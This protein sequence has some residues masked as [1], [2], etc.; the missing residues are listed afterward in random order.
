LSGIATCSKC[1]SSMTYLDK[2]K[3]PKGSCYLAC[4]KK[5]GG[6]CNSKYAR[7]DQI[8]KVV[9][10]AFSQ[11]NLSKIVEPEKVGDRR[12]DIEHAIDEVS[13]RMENFTAV[14]G[15][16]SLS[17]IKALDAAESEKLQLE[18]ELENLSI[19]EQAQPPLNHLQSV[20]DSLYNKKGDELYQLREQLHRLLR[21]AVE[22]LI[23]DA[24]DKHLNIKLKDYRDKVNFPAADFVW[25][26]TIS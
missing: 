12:G 14:I 8:E 21:G 19:Q 13:K 20:I 10:L 24:D 1:G 17:I 3:P 4:T 26:A 7:Y 23:V 18:T 16:G 25:A 6:T 2:G 5:I 11:I 9:T 15:S 22:H